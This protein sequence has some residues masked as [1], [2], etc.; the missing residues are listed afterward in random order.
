M[1]L[2][3]VWIIS[4]GEYSDYRVLGVCST[5][6]KA[7]NATALFDASNAPEEF[8]LDE[9]DT[10]PKGM[11]PWRIG[12]AQDGRVVRSEPCFRFPLLDGI[13]KMCTIPPEEPFPCFWLEC[14]A[15]DEKHAIKITN[16][17]RAQSIA[18]VELD[19]FKKEHGL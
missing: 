15:R 19:R 2:R 1:T 3:K 10:I 17:K 4:D 14:Y 16:E 8:I 18:M 5:E 7:Q 11:K 12:M 13:W 9:I 6:K